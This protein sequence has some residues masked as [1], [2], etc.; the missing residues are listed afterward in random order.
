[1][2]FGLLGSVYQLAPG[3]EGYLLWQADLIDKSGEEWEIEIQPTALLRSLFSAMPAMDDLY[4][5]LVEFVMFYRYR[6]IPGFVDAD[7]ITR[8]LVELGMTPEGL[9]TLHRRVRGVTCPLF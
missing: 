7:A 4:P 6:G 2:R 3:R 9:M 5:A 8:R 1:M